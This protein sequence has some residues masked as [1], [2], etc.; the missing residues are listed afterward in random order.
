M[1]KSKCRCL[2]FIYQCSK[3]HVSQE[4]SAER[5]QQE[6]MLQDEKKDITFKK[7]HY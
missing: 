2:L 7:K 5:K 1:I 6:T 3:F 4:A